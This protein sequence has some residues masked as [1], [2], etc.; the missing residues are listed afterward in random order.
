MGASFSNEIQVNHVAPIVCFD[1]IAGYTIELRDEPLTNDCGLNGKDLLAAQDHC[2][3]LRNDCNYPNEGD[4]VCMQVEPHATGIYHTACFNYSAFGDKVTVKTSKTIFDG[5]MYIDKKEPRDLSTHDYCL[6][7]KCY[8]PRL[9]DEPWSVSEEQ[10]QQINGH[11]ASISNVEENSKVQYVLQNSNLR[12]EHTAYIGLRRPDDATS[13]YE[14][15][16]DG[17]PYTY[18]NWA[19]NEPNA[20]PTS[21]RPSQC[22]QAYENAAAMIVSDGTWQDLWSNLHVRNFICQVEASVIANT[23][24]YLP[25]V[26]V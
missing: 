18:E 26:E 20:K 21:C 8:I 6:N 3:N 12:G 19:Y 14:E 22:G 2:I 15:W 10:C 25:I 17:A 7:G 13:P 9:N 11:L 24:N 5:R 16:S 1:N 23:D 4:L